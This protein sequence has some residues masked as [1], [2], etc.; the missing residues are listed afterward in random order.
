MTV[1]SGDGRTARTEDR[2]IAGRFTGRREA[3]PNDAAIPG[4][5]FFLF[6]PW[7]GLLTRRG[8][9]LSFSI[10]FTRPDDA[11][12][13]NSDHLMNTPLRNKPE[14]TAWGDASNNPLSRTPRRTAPSNPPTMGAGKSVL[15]S[16]REEDNS[17]TETAGD[18]EYEPL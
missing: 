11:W 12:S 10:L 5:L 14:A 8:L 7:P 15:A 17:L 6:C 1:G 2:G 4:C 3:R 18:D 9:R 16:E 13:N